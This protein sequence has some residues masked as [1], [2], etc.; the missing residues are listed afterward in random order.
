MC[1][2]FEIYA[3]S[4]I[5][6]NYKLKVENK[7]RRKNSSIVYIYTKYRTC[8]VRTHRH[9][10]S[11]KNLNKIASHLY[12]YIHIYIY[13][14][15]QSHVVRRNDSGFH[16]NV[17]QH[18][19]PASLLQNVQSMVH[20]SMQPHWHAG[21]IDANKKR[22]SFHLCRW[23]EIAPDQTLWKSWWGICRNAELYI[24]WRE[25]KNYSN[26]FGREKKEGRDDPRR[27]AVHKIK[28]ENCV[29]SHS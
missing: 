4:F 5:R 29:Y 17:I 25:R 10:L 11:A 14:I 15:Q 22:T 2:F 7:K 3:I 24:Y 6:I 8:L 27:S 23:P 12:I 28:I 13:N 21:Q 18:L 1:I 9:K 20:N 19:R 26:F 16:V